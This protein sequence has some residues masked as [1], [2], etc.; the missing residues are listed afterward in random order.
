METRSQST[1]IPTVVSTEPQRQALNAM[2]RDLTDKL[3]LMIAEQEAR[4]L[5]FTSIQHST[6]ILPVAP[7][8]GQ[9]SSHTSSSATSQAS[10]PPLIT[11]SPA[12]TPPPSTTKQLPQRR[13]IIPDQE[14]KSEGLSGTSIAVIIIAIIVLLKAC[15]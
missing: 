13:A 14:N 12:N 1:A 5:Q 9:E 8:H 2:S 15:S 7:S 6:S 3:N 10:P 11:H 4:V